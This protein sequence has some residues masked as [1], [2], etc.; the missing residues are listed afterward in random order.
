MQKV[1]IYISK[2]WY[3]FTAGLTARHKTYG[4]GGQPVLPNAAVPLNPIRAFNRQG[5]EKVVEQ[6]VIGRGE[7]GSVSARLPLAF[8]HKREAQLAL[9][10][11]DTDETINPSFETKNTQQ[12]TRRIVT[13]RP[14]RTM[15][16]PPLP[17]TLS[18]AG[19][20]LESA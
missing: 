11:G 5:R 7:S 6:Q 12:Y 9:E 13:T 10:L 2:H 1:A 4:G 17:T 14:V 16:P 3:F 19:R 18:Q 8:E 20:P 15:R